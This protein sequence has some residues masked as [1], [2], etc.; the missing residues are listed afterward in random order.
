[1]KKSALTVRFWFVCLLV[2]LALGTTV[3]SGDVVTLE[4]GESL[5]GTFSRIRQN[6]LIFRTSLEGQMMTPMGSV[7][8]L[9]V[10]TPLYIGM[11]DGRVFYG[12]LAAKEGEQFLVPL[13]GGEPV[14][15]HLEDINETLPIPTPPAGA[16]VASGEEG[17]RLGV[18]PGAQW[19]SDG[20]GV[21][22]V[23]RFDAAGRMEDWIV[24]GDAVVERSDPDRFPAYLRAQGELFYDTGGE[25]LPFVGMEFERDMDRALRRR[26]TLSLGLYHTLTAESTNALALLAALGAEQERRR[27]EGALLAGER[28]RSE[29]AAG[30][31]LGLR[32]YHLFT[33][34]HALSETL[35]FFADFASLGDF[36]ARSETAYLLPIGNRLQ[37]RVDLNI[38]YESRS[39]WRGVDRW[40]T[41][42]GAGIKMDF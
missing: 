38:D 11:T 14:P 26:S 7:K 9:S 17:W 2:G 16:A 28:Y 35:T 29:T 1:M 19:R 25:T 5:S 32:F 22:P 39:Y 41:T 34:G 20:R 31:R 33:R 6:T 12:R 4:S 27:T 40:S 36:R 10:D 23:L 24:S 15:I 30:L 13:D 42:V 3:A 18:T 37:L 8:T 21:E